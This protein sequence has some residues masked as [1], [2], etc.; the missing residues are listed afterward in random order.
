MPALK[1]KRRPISKRLSEARAP[2]ERA[3]LDF[4]KAIFLSA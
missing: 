4:L 3:R 2:M 1:L